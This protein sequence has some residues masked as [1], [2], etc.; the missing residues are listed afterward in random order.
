[1]AATARL[2]AEDPAIASV[3]FCTD[4]CAHRMW[5][6]EGTDLYIVC[7]SLAATTVRRYAADAPIAIVPP[8]VRAPFYAAPSKEAA[9]RSVGVPLDAPCVLL[10][11]GG[12]GLGPL[13]DTAE[14][15]ARAGYH[16]LAVAGLNRRLYA[17]LREVAGRVDVVV[18]FA[19]TNRIPELMAAAD[20]V[21][22]TPGQTCHEARV[23]GR[24]LV[25]LDIVPGHGRENALHELEAGGA[26]A[27]SP[28]PRSVTAAVKVVF[29][30]RP[31]HPPWPVRDGR[32]WEKHFFGALDTVG[33]GVGRHRP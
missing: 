18:P 8:P 7:S 26:L 22:T 10:M 31:E 19:M 3:A 2:R 21:L 13:A 27:C 9:R 20:A 16:V 24:W 14:A 11:S 12:W 4:A 29:E 23:V 5:I 15:L 28:E 17:R 6:A 32:D 1:V 25:V 30:E 33:I